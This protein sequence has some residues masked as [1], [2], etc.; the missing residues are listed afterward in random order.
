MR[1]IARTWRPA[2]YVR[3]TQLRRVMVNKTRALFD[4]VDLLVTVGA[5]GEAPKMEDARQFTT[6]EGPSFTTPFNLTGL[7]AASVPCGFGPNGLPLGI[8]IA[9]RPFRDDLALAAAH[10]SPRICRMPPLRP[11]SSA[12]AS[13]LAAPKKAMLRQV[14]RGGDKRETRRRRVSATG[15]GGG[16]QRR[17]RQGQAQKTLFGESLE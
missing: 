13:T 8:Q 12:S 7:P 3:A 5:V 10:A 15:C 14:L 16:R 17:Q 9:A 11:P 2:D 6:L 1:I 4:Q